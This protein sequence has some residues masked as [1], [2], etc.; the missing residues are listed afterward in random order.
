MHKQPSELAAKLNVLAHLLQL[1]FFFQ[2]LCDSF[3]KRQQ[4]GVIHFF[5]SPIFSVSPTMIL[6]CMA[7]ASNPKQ[8]KGAS[9][10]SA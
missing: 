5:Q 7:A 2:Q 9:V 4:F 10:L 6:C 1:V 3:L 8:F